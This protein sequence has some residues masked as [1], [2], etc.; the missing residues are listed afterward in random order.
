MDNKSE[1][2]EKK[3]TLHMERV[4]EQFDIDNG[5]YGCI[6]NKNFIDQI[7]KDQIILG[8]C[9]QKAPRAPWKTF[10]YRRK[11]WSM[12]L[13]SIKPLF[14]LRAK[15]ELGENCFKFPIV[16]HEKY[17]PE[18]ERPKSRE[19]IGPTVLYVSPKTPVQDSWKNNIFDVGCR[20]TLEFYSQ[21]DGRRLK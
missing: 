1:N 21:E 11:E 7:Q 3:F 13:G 9:P 4:K 20:V 16:F 5:K 15:E 2:M 14:S 12:A 6:I 19:L 18:E 8:R 10:C 17:T